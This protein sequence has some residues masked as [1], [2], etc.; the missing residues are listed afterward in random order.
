[1]TTA[2]PRQIALAFTIAMSAIGLST[3]PGHAFSSEAREMCTGDA[4]RLCSDEI[5][6]IS[7]IAAC[8]H[9]KKAQLS[10]GCRAVMNRE[11]SG[12]R[13]KRAAVED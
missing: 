5:P 1:M 8:M 7:R 6:N 3:S 2:R 12:R 11:A 9:R 10:P 4:M 13:N